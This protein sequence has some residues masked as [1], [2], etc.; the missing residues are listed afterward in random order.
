MRNGYG[1]QRLELRDRYVCVN[2]APALLLPA[3]VPVW[4]ELDR[5]VLSQTEFPHTLF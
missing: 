3:A 2:E 1:L 5:T 4:S